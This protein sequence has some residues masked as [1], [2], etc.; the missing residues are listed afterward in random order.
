MESRFAFAKEIVKEAGAFLR[1]HCLD[2]LKIESKTNPTDL[3]TQFD[4]QVQDQLIGRIHEL[5]P[6]DHILAEENNVRHD[7]EDGAVWVIDPID[8]TTNFI[9]QQADF[10][11][12]VA[13][14]QDG[15]GQFGIIYDVVGDKIYAGGG[16]FPVT[17]NDQ[18]LKAYSGKA[19]NQSL[20]AVNAGIYRENAWGLADY[21][22]QFLG[23]RI[24]G[25][26]GISYSKIFSGQLWAYVSYICPWDYAAAKILGQALGY[27]LMTVDGQEPNFKG[28]QAIVMLPEAH[29]NEFLNFVR[30]QA[31][32]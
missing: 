18:P 24:V 14:Y 11:V 20:F 15:V 8:G 28:S 3:V 25:S 4:S 31:K 10:A 19:K 29:Q 9:V 27:C 17:C 22:N 23:V 7:I 32:E 30:K 5:Y 13:F 21:A 16:A 12:M 6:Q 1:Q 2:E 26:A